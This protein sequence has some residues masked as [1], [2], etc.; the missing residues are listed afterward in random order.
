MAVGYPTNAFTAGIIGP[1]DGS[2]NAS[3]KHNEWATTYTDIGLDGLFIFYNQQARSLFPFA[4]FLGS[5]KDQND[6]HCGQAI[7]TVGSTYC[8]G[9]GLGIGWRAGNYSQATDFPLGTW[10]CVRGFIENAG[11]SNQRMRIWFQGPNM[12]SERLILDFTMDASQLDNKQGYK[13]MVWNAYANTNSGFGYI[14]STQVTFRYED[15]VH[16]RAGTPVPCSQI[17][18]TGGADT[19]P[20][21]APTGVQ[22][23]HLN[24]AR[25]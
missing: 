17:G 6:T 20:P 16:A 8:A 2:A 9:S 24:E 3:W 19:V 15:N 10:G 1:T 14:P 5:F 7:V 23:S 11:L 18:F 25:R 22:I 4:G 13:A 21:E 12:T